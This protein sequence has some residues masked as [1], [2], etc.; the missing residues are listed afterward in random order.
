LRVSVSSAMANYSKNDT[1]FGFG[2][3]FRAGE[4]GRGAKHSDGRTK[5]QNI[6]RE[7]E[8]TNATCQMDRQ[9]LV[10]HASRIPLQNSLHP[11]HG[12][13]D[14]KRR[15]AHA[16]PEVLQPQTTTTVN[17]DFPLAP[18]QWNRIVVPSFYSDPLQS[19]DPSPYPGPTHPDMNRNVFQSRHTTPAEFHCPYRD[20]GLAPFAPPRPHQQLNPSPF[21]SQYSPPAVQQVST[22]PGPFDIPA[23]SNRASPPSLPIQPQG[24]EGNKPTPARGRRKYRPT[25]PVCGQTFTKTSSVTTH[26][27]THT[28]ERNWACPKCKRTFGTE[29]NLNRHC[30]TVCKDK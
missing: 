11:R 28:G 27:I 8:G 14:V 6:S 23:Y 19:D 20:V 21:T 10:Q 1:T 22:T 12:Q 15:E 9:M 16:A 29:F 25:C 2:S 17:P 3:E 5:F 24:V 30:R 7:L 18:N 13:S 26:M 4:G